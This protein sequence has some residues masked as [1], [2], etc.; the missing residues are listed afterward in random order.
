MSCVRHGLN[1]SC[2]FWVGH[3]IFDYYFRRGLDTHLLNRWF[4]VAKQG[5]VKF[6]FS[7][8]SS[9]FLWF[10]LVIPVPL[11]LGFGF[12]F[13]V[14]LWR[15]HTQSFSFFSFGCF[16]GKKCIRMYYSSLF[17]CLI[18]KKRPWRSWQEWLL[19]L[20]PE[21]EREEGR[22]EGK[23]EETGSLYFSHFLTFSSSPVV[24]GSCS[25]S[26][27]SLLNRLSSSS[28]VLFLKEQNYA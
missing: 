24:L 9:F 22:E 12:F 17:S 7:V 23:E 10:S 6:T 19:S 2:W 20:T 15:S 11:H 3:E 1:M 4:F 5:E 18:Y 28:Q 27:T 21:K 14:N 8:A 16:T 25:H 26:R 13:I